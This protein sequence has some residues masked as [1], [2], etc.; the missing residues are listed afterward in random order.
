VQITR[1]D[2]IVELLVV[3]LELPVEIDGWRA[4]ERLLD[5]EALDLRAAVAIERSE[6]IAQDV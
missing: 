2:R 6:A 1:A 4:H 3:V 5:P